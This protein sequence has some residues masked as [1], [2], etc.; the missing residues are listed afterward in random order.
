MIQR[1]DPT[2]GVHRHLDTAVLAN[3]QLGFGIDFFM[4][5]GFKLFRTGD[6][7]LEAAILVEQLDS[8]LTAL[9]GDVIA[10]VLIQSVRFAWS[11]L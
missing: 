10:V 6:E 11:S 1:H 2:S 8:R 3:G 9:C 5:P 7:R 4:F